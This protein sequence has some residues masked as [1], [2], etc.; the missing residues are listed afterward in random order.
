[1]A[2]PR[3][4]ATIPLDKKVL[5]VNELLVNE[6][7][8]LLYSPG[9]DVWRSFGSFIDSGLANG[10][11]CLYAYDESNNKL[12]LETIFGE[13]L[14]SGRLLKFPLGKGYL[15]KEIEELGEKLKELCARSRSEK[16]AARVLVDFGALLTRHSFGKA[17][18][19]LKELMARKEEF[20]TP[21]Q[22]RKRQPILRTAIVAFNLESLNEEEI[23]TLLEINRNVMIST[24]DGTNTLALNFRSRREIPELELAPKESLE[25]FVKRHLET[26]VLS[27]LSE[28]PMCGYDVIKTIYQ[29]YYTS[30]SQGTVYSLLYSLEAR[31]LVTIMKGESMRSKIYVL[32]EQGRALAESRINDF[33]AAQRYLL[34]SIQR[35]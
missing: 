26:I 34:E 8:L 19:F 9:V 10:E 11:T 2:I 20:F 24:V 13:A 33:I 6:C 21:P 28:R 35:T 5:L 23:K 27:M 3:N 29:R 18:T 17:F 12:Q 31:G 1:M 32:T 22:E 7:S 16:C 14:S 15:P 25:H 30:L 4:A